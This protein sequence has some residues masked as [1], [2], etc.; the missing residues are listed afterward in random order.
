MVPEPSQV[1]RFKTDLD[2]LIPV[3]ARIGIAVSGGPDSLALLLLAAAVRPGKIEAATVDHGLRPDSHDEAE[4]VADLC[5]TLEIRH[6]LLAAQW[7][8][9]P[10]TAIQERAREERYR[11]LAQWAIATDLSAVATGHHLDDQAETLLMRL[12]RGAGVRGLSGMRAK[13]L[14]PRSDII[15]LRPLLGWRHAELEEVCAAAALRPARDTSNEDDRFERVRVRRALAGTALLD[16]SA[17]AR[18]AA[19]LGEAEVALEWAAAQEWED[20]ATR[21]GS[22]IIY[23]PDGAPPE[24]VRRVVS[25]AVRTLGTESQHTDLRGRELDRLLARLAAA[26][27][28]TI[29]GVRCSGGADWRFTQAPRRKR[30][31]DRTPS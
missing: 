19:N 13:S 21:S 26:E 23:R 14:L 5:S 12:A 22:E 10:V 9:K 8:E 15:L 17:L 11:L 6:T 24:I 4:I 20:R 30:P 1:R 28:A 18:S 2:Q 27:P 25:R 3:D 7:K 16:P 29:R 31:A